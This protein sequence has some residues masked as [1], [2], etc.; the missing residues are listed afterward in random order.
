MRWF[1]AD[2]ANFIKFS[3]LLNNEPSKFYD[4]LFVKLMLDRFWWPTQK[5]ILIWQF[6]PAMVFIFS[7]LLFYHYELSS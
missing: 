4:T 7:T 5:I 2:R 1:Y 6:L 3:R